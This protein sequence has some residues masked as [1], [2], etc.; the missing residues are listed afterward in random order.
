MNTYESCAVVRP[1][2]SSSALKNLEMLR[3]LFLIKILKYLIPAQKNLR[4]FLVV[5][6]FQI[7]VFQMIFQ[8][9]TQRGPQT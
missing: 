9:I 4:R 5:L 6:K 2:S 8:L 1:S 7:S 3:T